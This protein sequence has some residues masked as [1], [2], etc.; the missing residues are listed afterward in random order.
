[1]THRRLRDLIEIN[2]AELSYGVVGQG[3]I[4]SLDMIVRNRADNPQRLR[5]KA[6]RRSENPDAQD[7]NKIK[8]V[9]DTKQLAM[10][11]S[12][13]V[14]LELHAD[15]AENATYDLVIEGH[16]DAAYVVT[17][18]SALIIP[19]DGYKYFAKSLSLQNKP[20]LREGVK[21]IGV[22]NKV[23]DK[24]MAISLAGTA[25]TSQTSA[26][27]IMAEALLDEDDIDDIIDYPITQTTYWDPLSK[28]LVLDPILNTVS[29]ASLMLL[30]FR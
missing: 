21:I 29:L 23:E 24:S 1:M 11:C 26:T 14:K 22:A 7:G 8:A 18:L 4:Y 30:D 25:Y 19:M 6:H 16:S 17:P 13:L 9:Y 10:G 5:I 28:K 3:F 2:P 15:F 12:I 27:S 20:V